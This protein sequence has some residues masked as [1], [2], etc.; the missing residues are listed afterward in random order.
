MNKEKSDFTQGSIL[1]KLIPFMIP[2]LGALVLQAAYGAV[3]LLVVGRFG[4][5]A[6]LSAVST[7]SQILNLVTFVITQLAMGITVLI[8]RYIGEKS[9]GQIGQLL[10]GAVTVFAIVSAVLF[11]VMVFFAKP[12]AVLMQAP[13]EAISLTTVYVRICGGGIFFI[14]AYNVLAAIFRGLGDSRS[15]LIFVAVACVV[16]IIG[17]LIL[18][19]GFHLD[20]AGAAIATVAAQAVSV[21]LAIILLKKK[22]LKFGIQKKDFRIN[23]QCK[24][25]LKV[26][27]PLALQEFLT[28]MSFLALCAFVNKLGLEASSGYGV[29]CKIVNFAMLVPSSLMQSMASFVSQNVGAGKPDRAKKSMFT[30]M[31]LGVI[32]GVV[33][34]ICVWCFGDVLTSV[35]TTDTAVIQKGTEYLRGFAPE[36]IVTAVLFSMVGFFNGY[37]KTVWVMIQGLVQ[38]LLVRLPLA[39]VMSIQPHAS[40]TKIGL[41][42]PVATCFGIV[43]NVIFYLIFTRKMEWERKNKELL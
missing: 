22:D 5:T 37:E 15:P 17:D 7:G 10:G 19:A 33:V 23:G 26:G 20:A 27:L 14:V 38:T 43:L 4:S 29:A 31:G 16:N 36:T 3:D 35:F 21:V 24:R 34:F 2:I 12:L 18:V 13:Q 8:A 28:Q 39:Y 42:A 40:L 25:F 6:G 32:V 30:G 1:K 41:A 11:V 9:T